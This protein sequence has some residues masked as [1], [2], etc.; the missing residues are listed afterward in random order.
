MGLA[1]FGRRVSIFGIWYTQVVSGEQPLWRY[2]ITWINK[3]AL[4]GIRSVVEYHDS[5]SDVETW[6]SCITM[7]IWSRGGSGLAWC[8]F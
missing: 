5:V 8:G 3:V 1:G 7:L 4:F 6:L 2:C